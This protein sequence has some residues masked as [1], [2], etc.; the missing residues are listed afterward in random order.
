M[1]RRMKKVSYWVK[2]KTTSLKETS[3]INT[4]NVI[5]FFTCVLI[6]KHFILNNSWSNFTTNPITDVLLQIIRAE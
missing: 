4:H 1:N 3:C 6:V 5:S 2:V